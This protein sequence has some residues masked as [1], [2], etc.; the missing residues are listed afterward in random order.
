MQS[1]TVKVGSGDTVRE[2]VQKLRKDPDVAYAVPN[3][4]AHASLTPNDPN[5]GLQWNLNSL[6]RDQRS[7]RV[8]HRAGERRSRRP[9]GDRRGARH[10]RRLR[11]LPPLPPRARPPALRARLRLRGR[12]PPPQRP[13]RPRHP[14]VGD[15]RREHGQR[16]GHRG[17]RLPGEDHA[18]ARAR[19]RRRRRH[20]L[21]QP[22]HP[23]RR[24]P[25]REGDQ[26]QPRVRLLGAGVADPRHRVGPALRAAQGVAGGGGGRQPGRH[27]GG[28]PRAREGRDRGRGHHDPRLPGRLLQQRRGRGHHGARRRRGRG[29]LRSPGPLL[30]AGLQ[31]QRGGQLHLPADLHLQRAPVRPAAGLRGHVDG[32]AARLGDRRAGD[33]VEAPRARSRA[34]PRSSAISRRRRATSA[35]RASTLATATACWTQRPRCGRQQGCPT[36]PPSSCSPAPAS[37]CWSSPARR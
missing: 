34:R 29:D 11:A 30:D 10:R 31:P 14:R 13:Q 23:L 6:V 5:F 26:P 3:Y 27:A 18:R 17:H 8:G 28:L 24:P 25:R 4:I 32:R 12:R 35:G 16:R 33:R 9:R 22:R 37:R 36:P 1:K 15:D 19:R 21:D 7:R 2:T 20:P